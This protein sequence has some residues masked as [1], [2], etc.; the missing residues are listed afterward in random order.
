MLNN[1]VMVGRLAND[2]ELTENENKKHTQIT[3]AIPR[4]FKNNNGEYDTDFINILLYGN[5]AENVIDCCHKG[6]VLGVKGRVTSTAYQDKNED[7]KLKL[8]IIA[9]KVSFLSRKNPSKDFE[10]KSAR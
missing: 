2:P 9:E 6:D 3:L 7:N 5:I 1:V 4:S 8:E 10:D